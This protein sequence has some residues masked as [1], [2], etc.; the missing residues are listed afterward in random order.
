MK[1]TKNSATKASTID[2]IEKEKIK[3]IMA[4]PVN[5]RTTSLYWLSQGRFRVAD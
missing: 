1:G 5:P 2:P 3:R 4:K